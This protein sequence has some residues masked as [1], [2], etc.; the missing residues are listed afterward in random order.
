MSSDFESRVRARQ[1]HTPWSTISVE[2]LL[3]ALTRFGEAVTHLSVMPR[4]EVASHLW[5]ALE[6]TAA[7]GKRQRV[8]VSSCD[9]LLWRP[10][11]VEAACR[12][13]LTKLE[14]GGER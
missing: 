3:T 9:R 4:Q 11:E 10:A 7:T 8:E 1:E 13:A 14:A 12:A 2:R 6:W 5:W